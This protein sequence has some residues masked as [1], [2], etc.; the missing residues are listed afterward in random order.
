MSANSSASSEYIP[1]PPRSDFYIL[2]AN[3]GVANWVPLSGDGLLRINGTN[4][5]VLNKTTSN[6]LLNGGLGWTQTEACP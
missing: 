4:I 5:S 2:V 6:E 1:D 3:G